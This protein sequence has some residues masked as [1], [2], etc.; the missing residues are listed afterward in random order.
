MDRIGRRHEPISF[1]LF[2]YYLSFCL[3]RLN[4]YVFYI[5]IGTVNGN[6]VNAALYYIFIKIVAE[7][8]RKGS[9]I[10]IKLKRHSHQLGYS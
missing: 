6:Q 2:R 9:L 10:K 1:L 3:I 8:K 4:Q 5:G 7:T